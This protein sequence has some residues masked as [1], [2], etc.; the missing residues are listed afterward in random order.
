MTG[1]WIKCQLR[2]RRLSIPFRRL[3][4]SLGLSRQC[5]RL[6]AAFHTRAKHQPGQSLLTRQFNTT[7]VL[8][9]REEKKIP[10]PTKKQ[11]AAKE[12]RK[13]LKRRQ[14]YDSEKMPLQEAVAVL[15]VRIRFADVA[16]PSAHISQRQLKFPAPKRL[17]K[18]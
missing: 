10:I 12:R 11:M 8:L 2:F 6:V 4:M 1:Q 5:C 14:M 9:A 3:V 13:A 16:L 7:S 15:R 18:S 17:W